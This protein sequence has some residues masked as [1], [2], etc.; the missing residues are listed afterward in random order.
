VVDVKKYLGIGG[1]PGVCRQPDRPRRL[2][3]AIFDW[4]PLW[5]SNNVAYAEHRSFGGACD[6][7][8]RSL[9]DTDA[10]AA[11]LLRLVECLICITKDGFEAW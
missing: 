4:S 7:L 2:S 11:C 5:S 3:R 1:N 6:A 10:I 8:Q 9:R